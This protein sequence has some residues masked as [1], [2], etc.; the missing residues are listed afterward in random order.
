MESL[1][2]FKT[3][4]PIAS[5]GG[6]LSKASLGLNSLDRGSAKVKD[7][8]VNILGLAGFRWSLSR[9]LNSTIPG[10]KQPR[11]TVKHRSYVPITF[12]SQEQMEARTGPRSAV[13]RPLHEG[14]LIYREQAFKDCQA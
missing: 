1:D 3:S 10:P 5:E 12:Y 14:L 9:L 2:G 8:P 4:G 11:T 7:P 13:R 6:V